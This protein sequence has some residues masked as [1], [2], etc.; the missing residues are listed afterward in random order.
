VKT[1]ERAARA[2]ARPRLRL[3]V[4]AHVGVVLAIYALAWYVGGGFA[5]SPF[6]PDVRPRAPASTR[7]LPTVRATD[8]AV[9]ARASTSDLQARTS[10]DRPAP[11]R[12]DAEGRIQSRAD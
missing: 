8:E 9:D 1:I 2:D 7:L 6:P 11:W 4:A 12:V 3:F 5:S 10:T